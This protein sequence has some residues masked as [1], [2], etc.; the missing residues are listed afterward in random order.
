MSTALA[1]D[2][3]IGQVV[4]GRYE[5]LRR[6]GKG[7]MGSIYEVRHQRLQR[8]FALKTLSEDLAQNTEALARFRREADII[9]RLRHP[10]IVE[11]VDWED[12]PGGIPCIVMEL[13]RGEPLSARIKRE[14]QL[15]WETIALVGDRICSALA[16]AH[17]AG[18]VHRDL[19]PENIF[20]HVDDAGE[21]RPKL[22]DFGVSKVHNSLTIATADER[23]LGTPAYMS[24]E[25]ADGIQAEIG[26]ASD[27]WAVGAILFEMAAGQP[28]FQGPSVPS[29][30]YQ[31]CHGKPLELKGL[32]GNVPA[33]F[34]QVIADAMTRS[35]RRIRSADVLRARLRHAFSELPEIR[36]EE[37]LEFE[38][39]DILD[40]EH[41]GTAT[42]ISSS[43]GQSIAS[44]GPQRSGRRTPLLVAGLVAATAAAILVVQLNGNE[45][46]SVAPTPRAAAAPAPAPTPSPV[47]TAP[48]Q[49][50]SIQISITSTPPGAVVYRAVDGVRIGETPFSGTYKR[51]D[52]FAE[53]QLRLEG[54]ELASI[55]LPTTAD[56][57]REVALQ[58]LVA[59]KQSR[60]AKKRTKKKR[61]KKK[62]SGTKKKPSGLGDGTINP[63][64][65]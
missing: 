54:Y 6:I 5:V 34:L 35:N 17:K 48:A 32:R 21:A 37:T 20:L 18:V 62:R 28:A 7:G 45:S 41:E 24:P 55:S 27:V 60:T 58:K 57:T 46:R 65:N 40:V 15:S 52:G 59:K 33:A 38:L 53:F 50:K 36:Y 2:R 10:N 43:A 31:V 25:Q 19:K 63:F 64:G 61:T 13:L 22:L 9:A 4:A 8:N 30:L 23:L 26:P 29:L 11:V 49:P 16:V 44:T 47:V 1:E 51:G 42:T 12:L 14:K 56:G 39:S 3:L